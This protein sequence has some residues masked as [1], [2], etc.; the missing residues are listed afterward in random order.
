MHAPRPGRSGGYEL[1]K[2]A[3]TRVRVEPVE[4]VFRVLTDQTVEPAKRPRRACV[5]AQ[6]AAATPR[7]PVTLGRCDPN[8]E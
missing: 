2:E 4:I 6:V 7:L 8:D 5:R 1:L 3:A